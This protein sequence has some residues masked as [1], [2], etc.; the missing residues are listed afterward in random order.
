MSCLSGKILT[1]I[2][3][4]LSNNRNLRHCKCKELNDQLAYLIRRL[5]HIALGLI[6]KIISFH[7]Q[8]KKILYFMNT[9]K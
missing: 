7:N 9:L 4:D 8:K 2:I 1:F 3:I 5:H 6:L